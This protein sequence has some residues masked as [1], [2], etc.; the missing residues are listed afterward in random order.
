L[1]EHSL[2][3]FTLKEAS[4]LYLTVS[5]I[6]KRM[7]P[8]N[9]GYDYSFVKMIL[10]KIIEGDDQ[11]SQLEFVTGKCFFDEHVTLE[12]ENEKLEPGQYVVFIEVDWRDD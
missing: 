1:G 4:K 6:S 9:Q 12:Y 7:A 11:N 8:K 2:A 5:Q 3:R 10:A